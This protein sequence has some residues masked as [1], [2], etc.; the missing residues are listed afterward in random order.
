V[1]FFIS[2]KISSSSIMGLGL[3]TTVGLTGLSIA[4]NL[5]WSNERS[6]PPGAEGGAMIPALDSRTKEPLDLDKL[7][8]DKDVKNAADHVSKWFWAEFGQTP[9]PGLLETMTSAEYEDILKTIAVYDETSARR[10]EL[11]RTA[12]REI[13]MKKAFLEPTSMV[14]PYEERMNGYA[15]RFEYYMDAELM[16]KYDPNQKM[17]LDPT[18]PELPHMIST[19]TEARILAYRELQQAYVE[20]VKYSG[21]SPWLGKIAA[22]AHKVSGGVKKILPKELGAAAGAGGLGYLAIS[23]EQAEFSSQLAVFSSS[24]VVGGVAGYTCALLLSEI[25][26]GVVGWWIMPTINGWTAPRYARNVFRKAFSQSAR[27]KE[28]RIRLET[29]GKRKK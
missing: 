1:F 19:A 28:A 9:P 4:S 22:Y 15:R 6:N 26:K 18:A 17:P 11:E 12:N 3:M 21:W 20:M 16:L 13:L 14:F 29:F 24:A 7:D 27:A 10:L 23:G 25:P 2:K 8:Y 5:A